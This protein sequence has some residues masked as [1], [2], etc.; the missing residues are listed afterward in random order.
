MARAMDSELRNLGIPFFAIRSSLV[1]TDE[2]KNNKK[3]E[4]RAGTDGSLGLSSAVGTAAERKEATSTTISRT[5]L[6]TLQRRMLELL[7]DLCKD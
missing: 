5:E 1:V 4:G 7:Q 6:L 2:Q 3:E